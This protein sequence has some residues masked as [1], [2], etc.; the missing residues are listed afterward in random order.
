MH[1]TI[2]YQHDLPKIIFV[3]FTFLFAYLS[4]SFANKEM[5]H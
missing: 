3:S 2:Q 5:I 1:T 4:L